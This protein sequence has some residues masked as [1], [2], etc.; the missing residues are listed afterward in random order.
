M[1]STRAV[2]SP[3]SPVSATVVPARSSALA[4]PQQSYDLTALVASLAS[5]SGQLTEQTR[6]FTEHTRM[7]NDMQQDQRQQQAQL[8]ELSRRLPDAS[9]R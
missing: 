1:V 6:Q 4:P 2:H 7:F 8:D 5:I 3:P 9:H